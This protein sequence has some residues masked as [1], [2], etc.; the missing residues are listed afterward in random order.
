MWLGGGF[1]IRLKKKQ[2]RHG[3][4]PPVLII[5]LEVLR[6]SDDRDRHT[7]TKKLKGGFLRFSG[8]SGWGWAWVGLLVCC[9]D[10]RQQRS[11]L[12]VGY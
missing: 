10:S 8:G 4:A 6:A 9:R 11:T 7:H 2:L 5:L 3:Y 12:L 1:R